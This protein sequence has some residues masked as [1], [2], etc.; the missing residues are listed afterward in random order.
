M[1][2]AV[3]LQAAQRGEMGANDFLVAETSINTVVTLCS[4][5]Y[6]N[7][8]EAF[9]QVRLCGL[10]RQQGLHWQHL[11]CLSSGLPGLGSTCLGWWAK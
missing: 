1:S 9:R 8:P 10:G 4:V 5:L 7:K 2:C 6:A 3:M 11:T